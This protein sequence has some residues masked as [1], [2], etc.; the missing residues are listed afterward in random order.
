MLN[1]ILYNLVSIL[2]FGTSNLLWKIPQKEMGVFQLISMRSGLTTLL[3]GISLLVLTQNESSIYG[4]F[5]AISISAFSYWGLVFYNLSIKLSKVSH[6]ITITSASCL[7]G[8]LTAVFFYKESLTWNLILAFPLIVFGLFFLEQK[9]PLFKWSKGTL[10]ALIAA[11]F[12]GV[13]FALFKIPIEKIGSLNFSFALEATVFVL[14]FSIL[15]FKK[16]KVNYKPSK[17]S[18]ASIIALALLGYLGVVCY[19]LAITT[20]PNIST[21]SIMGSFTPVVTIILSHIVLKEKFSKIQYFGI[22]LILST[23]FLLI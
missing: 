5:I 20:I 16:Q 10:F 14:S 18:I 7:F 21:L 17:K 12:W 2:S 23:S 15:L 11:F 6:S 8:V 3:F 19:N 1:A 22:L 4:W 13:S 9:K